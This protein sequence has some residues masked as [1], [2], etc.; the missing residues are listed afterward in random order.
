MNRNWFLGAFPCTYE[1]NF[2]ASVSICNWT[3]DWKA[4][5]LLVMEDRAFAPQ[6][7]DFDDQRHHN[8]HKSYLD[9]RRS[10][11]NYSQGWRSRSPRRSYDCMLLNLQY[12]RV[13]EC[14]INEDGIRTVSTINPLLQLAEIVNHTAGSS[15]GGPV[16]KNRG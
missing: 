3:V 5:C 12:H 16:G 6:V 1:R 11:S 13:R 15:C 9:R 8:Y 7:A 4:G 10:P 14:E 2:N